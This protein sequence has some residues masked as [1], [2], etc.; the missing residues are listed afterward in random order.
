LTLDA[1][2]TAD[3]ESWLQRAR[4][5]PA[6]LSPLEAALGT[7][8]AEVGVVSGRIRQ[9][10]PSAWAD[11]Y[12]FN[13]LGY[14]RRIETLQLWTRAEVFSRSR[15]SEPTFGAAGALY[16][17]LTQL[18]LRLTASVKVE[19]QRVAGIQSKSWLTRGFVE[20]SYRA[21]PK[22]FILPR[23]GYDG[24]YSSV[25]RRP[26]ALAYVDD[27]I[28]SPYRLRRPTFL[29]AQALLWYA[30]YFNE[31]S[32]LRLRATFDAKAHALSHSAAVV[33][34]FLAFG[35]LD[36]SGEVQTTWYLP[37]DS[38]TNRAQVQTQTGVVARYS[39]WSGLG[40]LGITPGVAAA[41][42]PQDAA[43]QV[44]AFVNLTASFRR[45][46]RDFSS[47]ELDFPEQ[48]SGGIPWRGETPGGYR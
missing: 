5:S 34:A 38:L 17:D 13:L 33:G 15:S 16:E 29:F 8:V 47:L 45:G 23:L 46:L 18:H 4:R 42:R 37:R 28:Y 19:S 7:F 2:P 14:R 32:Y 39:F 44:T 12:A 43:W 1:R 26:T 22:F 27:E 30:P 35:D 25:A 9:N 24:M 36:L 31:I 21:T 11:A 6:P 41:A 40:S 10:S 3:E 20:Y 48:L